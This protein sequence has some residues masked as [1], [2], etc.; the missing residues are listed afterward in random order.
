MIAPF[1]VHPLLLLVM[2]PL[3]AV[4]LV[5][6]LRFNA[7]GRTWW[8]LPLSGLALAPAALWAWRM[9]PMEQALPQVGVLLLGLFAIRLL[10]LATGE[11]DREVL[12]LYMILPGLVWLPLL[13]PLAPLALPLPKAVLAALAPLFW[14]SLALVLLFVLSG[15][16][17]KFRLNR[18]PASVEGL[19][20]RLALV[21]FLLFFWD[22]FRLLLEGRV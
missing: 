10:R 7:F 21:A 1:N 4:V 17:E 12:E 20:F 13:F 2:G 14:L 11:R 6:Q 3:L 19:P 9:G 22:C 18:S 8:L 15:A 16:Q 5:R